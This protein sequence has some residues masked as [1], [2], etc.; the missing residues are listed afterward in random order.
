MLILNSLNMKSVINDLLNDI[1][2]QCY[3]SLIV[4]AGLRIS[5]KGFLCIKVCV[6]GGGVALLIVSHCS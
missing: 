3:L 5:E 2:V 4:R 1:Y 6:C